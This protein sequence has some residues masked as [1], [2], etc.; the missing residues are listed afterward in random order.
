VA[1]TY[2]LAIQLPTVRRI[3]ALTS[4]HRLVPPRTGRPA[5]RRLV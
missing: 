2:S 5:A 3:V 4:D 1:L